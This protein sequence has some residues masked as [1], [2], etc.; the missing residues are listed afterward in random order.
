MRR[1][2]CLR[3]FFASYVLRWQRSHRAPSSGFV[4]ILSPCFPC[5]AFINC[6]CT[7]PL[8]AFN[9]F[10]ISG[11][12]VVLVHGRV[13]PDG[14]MFLVASPYTRPC[15]CCLSCCSGFLVFLIGALA[16][17]GVAP[18]LHLFWSLGGF[19]EFGQLGEE[20]SW[21]AWDLL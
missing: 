19:G 9:D 21:C 20:M 5:A 8:L 17:C 10:W 12:S 11:V 16:Y 3:L 6:A 1:V 13:A 18:E 15:Y 2:G 7:A 14:S 4:L